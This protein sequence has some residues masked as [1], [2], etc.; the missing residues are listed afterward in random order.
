MKIGPWFAYIGCRDGGK[1]NLT[2]GTFYYKDKEE[3]SFENYNEIIPNEK[4]DREFK[5]K[6]IEIYKIDK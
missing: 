2:Q 6:E 1:S 4:K 5:V 3:M